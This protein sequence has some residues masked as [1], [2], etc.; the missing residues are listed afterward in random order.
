MRPPGEGLTPDM[1]QPT[2]DDEDGSPD[3][4]ADDLFEDD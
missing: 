3:I 2:G 1:F 4:P